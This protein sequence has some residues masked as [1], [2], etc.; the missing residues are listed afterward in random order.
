MYALPSNKRRQ[1]ATYFQIQADC[2][3]METE[4]CIL[5]KEFNMSA[6]LFVNAV[7]LKHNKANILCFRLKLC[8]YECGWGKL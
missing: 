2:V 7:L 4:S 8:Q 3:V 5:N 1:N 6:G